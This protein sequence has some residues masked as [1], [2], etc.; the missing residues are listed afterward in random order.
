MKFGKLKAK[1]IIL[2]SL[3]DEELIFFTSNKL[4]VKKEF[5]ENP[6]K[7]YYFLIGNTDFP[8]IILSGYYSNK[9]YQF[10]SKTEAKKFLNLQIRNIEK[11]LKLL[12]EL[13]DAK[14]KVNILQARTNHNIKN[15]DVKHFFQNPENNTLE[16]K[17]RE[18][19]THSGTGNIREMWKVYKLFQSI[20]KTM[21]KRKMKLKEFLKQPNTSF[22]FPIKTNHLI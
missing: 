11:D 2:K 9:Q 1:E 7:Y 3:K 18:F 20:I 8:I 15:H 10:R 16:F 13:F 12:Y 17:L 5:V 19:Y 14:L 21:Q 4:S 6:N 22:S